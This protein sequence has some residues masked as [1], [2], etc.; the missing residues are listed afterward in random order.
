[1]QMAE[2]SLVTDE[3]VITAGDILVGVVNDPEQPLYQ[4]ARIILEATAPAV[5]DQAVEA[6]ADMTAGW[7]KSFT[8]LLESED[9]LGHR[10]ES[11]YRA[12]ADTLNDLLHA[13]RSLKRSQSQ[14]G[15][16]D[17]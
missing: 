2:Q 17:A 16:G 14:T 3:M 7:L 8:D 9:D 6:C 10:L 12:Q 15:E 5:W 1:M 11:E 13:L 4:A